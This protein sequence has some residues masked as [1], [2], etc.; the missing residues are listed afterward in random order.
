MELLTIQAACFYATNSHTSREGFCV[1]TMH[2]NSYIQCVQ[3]PHGGVLV[4][5]GVYDNPPHGRHLCTTIQSFAAVYDSMAATLW[6]Q[7]EDTLAAAL[8]S[9]TM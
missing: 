8:A 5:W 1:G 2:N 4:T 7:P 3:S 6:A 9:S